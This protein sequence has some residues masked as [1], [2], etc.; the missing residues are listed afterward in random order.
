MLSIQVASIPIRK[1]PVIF[2]ESVTQGSELENS[3]QRINLNAEPNPPPRPTS[4]TN[5]VLTSLKDN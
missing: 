4:K 1:P 2:I 3:K 5:L